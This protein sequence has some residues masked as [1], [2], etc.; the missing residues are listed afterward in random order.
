LRPGCTAWQTSVV[1]ICCSQSVGCV[2]AGFVL[3]CVPT[4]FLSLR[5]GCYCCCHAPGDAQGMWSATQVKQQQRTAQRTAYNWHNVADFKPCIDFSSLYDQFL[6][7][8]WPS[9]NKDNS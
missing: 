6:R 5:S 2:M 3:L 7:A 4:K 8:C 1:P 9:C